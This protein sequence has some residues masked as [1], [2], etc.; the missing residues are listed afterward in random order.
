MVDIVAYLIDKKNN[1]PPEILVSDILE[2]IDESIY[3]RYHL[4]QL[5]EGQL[6]TAL[7]LQYYDKESNGELLSIILPELS[8][9][10]IKAIEGGVTIKVTD[11]S[12]GITINLVKDY[13]ET[14]YE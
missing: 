8:N 1:H 11:T 6:G 10:L 12:K 2:N 3:F 13:A 7:T 4:G 14:E 9:E 5:K